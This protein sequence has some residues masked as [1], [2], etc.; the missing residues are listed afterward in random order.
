MECFRIVIENPPDKG[1]YRVFNQFESVYSL[2]E[3]A[4]RVKEAAEEAGADEVVIQH[5]ENPRVEMEEHYYNPDREGL[6]KLGYKPTSEMHPQLVQMIEDL[7]GNK[8]RIDRGVLV[9]DVWWTGDRRKVKFD[10]E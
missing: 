6:V 3:L 5:V 2:R 4:G 9:P 10:H 8:D 1:E 7:S